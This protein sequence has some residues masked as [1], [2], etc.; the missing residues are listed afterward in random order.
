MRT[1]WLLKLPAYATAG[2]VMLALLGAPANAQELPPYMAPIAG[3]TVSSPA[4]TATK[5]VLA[6]N[7]MM[8][9]LY[10]NAAAVFQANILRNH[11]VILGLF[12]GAGGRFILY[13]PGM[14]PLEAPSVP[15]VYQLLKSVGHS[16]MALTEIVGPYLDNAA[17]QSW[18]GPMLA[19]RSRMKSAVD[20]LGATPMQAD[21]RDNSRAIL[22]NNI[23]FMDDCLEKGS[24]S[25]A[26]LQAF[27]KKQGPLLKRNITWAAQTQ[28]G[29]WMNMIGEWKTMLGSDWDKTY[30]ASNTIYV[31]RQNNI[32]FSVLAQY[33]G[34]EAINE[35]LMLIETISFTTTPDEMLTS[36]TRIIADRTVGALFFGNYYLMDYE[37]MG[38][39]AR[40]AIIAESEK[41]GM[42]PFLPPAVPFG[43][44]QW[45]TLITPGP[46][47]TS[48][49]DLP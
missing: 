28:V 14:A 24:I 47:P 2:S 38:G 10:D 36:L 25:L 31:A 15:I 11:P 9:E 45:P 17:D 22:E 12:T 43:S 39:D 4:E 48:L 6:L 42:K 46:G 19:Y 20:S 21:W 40:A 27:A 26:A 18:R 23:A 41:R 29:H 1:D 13:R 32:L 49:A 35:R 30:A 44:K 37:L 3:H 5:N 8:F 34:P 33:F 7:S 16:T